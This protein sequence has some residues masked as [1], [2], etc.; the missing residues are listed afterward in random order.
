M[1]PGDLRQL[2][3]RAQLRELRVVVRIGDGA[4]A[5]PITQREG[6]VI[7]A[8][9]LAKLFEVRIQKVLTMVCQAPC[10]K[11]GAAA[12]HDPGDAWRGEWYVSQQHARVHREVVDALLSLLDDGVSIDVPAEILGGAAHLFECLVDR[13]RADGHG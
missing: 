11:D 4:R 3:E 8:Q 13:H 9:D 2:P 12:R 7:R 10:R 5:Q 1:P 6:N